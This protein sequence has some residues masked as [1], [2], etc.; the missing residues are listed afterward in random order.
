M[1]TAAIVSREEW[2]ESRKA[3]LAQEKEFTRQRDA[4]SKKRQQLPWVEVSEDYL[5]DTNEGPMH[6]SQL[7]GEHSQLVVYHFMYGPEWDVGC[8]SCSFWADNYNGVVAH[9]A[10]RDVS[11]IAVSRTS[12]DNINNFSKRM[13]WSFPWVSSLNNQFNFDYDVS[14][15][16]D[17]KTSG[18]ASYNYKSGPIGMDELPGVSVFSKDEAGRLYHSYSTYSRGLDLMNTAYNILD[19]VPKGRDEQNLD[20]TMAWLRLHDSY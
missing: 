14:F 9:L 5:F 16:E 20:N 18:Q 12:L 8:K 11:L 2:L 19:L 10:A 3:L 1:T 6:L 4:L 15:T 7:F 17:D 13:N